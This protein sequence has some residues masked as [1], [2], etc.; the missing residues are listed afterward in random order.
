MKPNNAPPEIPP[1]ARRAVAQRA[2]REQVFR[3]TEQ[4]ILNTLLEKRGYVWRPAPLIEQIRITIRNRWR[5]FKR[6]FTWSK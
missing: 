1:H 6:F 2:I 5:K 3:N 4:R